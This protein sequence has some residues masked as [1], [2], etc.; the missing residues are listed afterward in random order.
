MP[1]K[2][3]EAPVLQ[4]HEGER[5][6]VAEENWGNFAQEGQRLMGTPH[7]GGE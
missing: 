7:D 2:R 3:Q 4:G 1:P 5:G 6:K